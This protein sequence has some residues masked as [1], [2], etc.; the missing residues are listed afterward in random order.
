MGLWG[1]GSG[2]EQADSVS[3]FLRQA[4]RNLSPALR[5]WLAPLRNFYV[6]RDIPNARRRLRAGIQPVAAQISEMSAQHKGER[7]FVDC[8]FNKGEVLQGFIDFLPKDLQ[9]KYYGFEVNAPLFA[10]AAADLCRRNPEIIS[11]EFQA[12]SDRDG[13]VEFFSSGTSHG[14]VVGE[15]TSIVPDMPA[16]VTRCAH[17]QKAKAIDFSKWV[18][19]IVRKHTSASGQPPYI[20]IKMDI[21][22]AECMVLEHMESMGTLNNINFLVIELHSYL[23]EGG[24][25]QEYEMREQRLLRILADKGVQVVQWG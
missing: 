19:E 25:R 2:Q 18:N 5:A 14:L 15:A 8:G 12:V 7:I 1:L 17:S 23:F 4:F 24:L 16:D 22:G 13:E 6:E 10:K 11:L 9:F 21:E 20:V 3:R